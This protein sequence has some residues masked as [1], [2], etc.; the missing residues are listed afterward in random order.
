[1][2]TVKE[3]FLELFGK[4]RTWCKTAKKLLKD[5]SADMYNSNRRPDIW[6]QG[7]AYMNLPKAKDAVAAIVQQV[8]GDLDAGDLKTKMLT[9]TVSMTDQEYDDLIA[10]AGP[11]R[12]QAMPTEHKLL[13]S[14]CR[15]LRHEKLPYIKAPASYFIHHEKRKP[16][17]SITGAAEVVADFLRTQVTLEEWR[18]S[19][20]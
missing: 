20:T 5:D 3:N 10:W 1:M 19:C 11:L 9:V 8:A 6:C 13:Y 14:A 7:L 12:N 18:G 17:Q 4:H 16:G 15:F 2:T